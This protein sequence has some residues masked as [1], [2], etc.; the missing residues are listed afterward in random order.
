MG[1]GKHTKNKRLL[2]I[3]GKF[4]VSDVRVSAVIRNELEMKME[5]RYIKIRVEL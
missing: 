5:L 4:A 3:D 1:V 2:T